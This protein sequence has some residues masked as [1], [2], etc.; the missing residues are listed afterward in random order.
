MSLNSFELFGFSDLVEVVSELHELWDFVQG[1][2]LHLSELV[3]LVVKLLPLI[4]V[5]INGSA[6][7]TLGS[8]NV[9]F[10][11]GLILHLLVSYRRLE[12]LSPVLFV[13]S[14]D[15]W[16]WALSLHIFDELG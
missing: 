15:L 7:V 8:L 14:L 2:V 13:K 4:V 3:V 1:V 11:G 12:N 9:D 16:G 10:T 5:N 6:E